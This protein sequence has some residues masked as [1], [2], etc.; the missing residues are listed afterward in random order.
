MPPEAVAEVDSWDKV[1]LLSVSV[2]HV[3]QW[4]QEG[5]LLIGDSA[6]A[7]SPLGGVGINY[8]IHDAVAA[9]NILVPAFRTNDLS[10]AVLQ[11]VQARR[12]KPV[13]RM[14]RIQVFAQ[15]HILSPILAQEHGEL[16]MPWFLKLF[17]IFPILR[18]IPARV[19][20]IGFG[21]E[22]VNISF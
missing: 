2:D 22:H 17:S 10:L 13:R 9:G 8:A 14:Q 4:A 18:R 21:A 11:N 6:H 12:E 1:K 19:L 3:K 16:K 7:M 20:G 5:M 15:D